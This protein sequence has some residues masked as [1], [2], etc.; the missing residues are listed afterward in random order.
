[1]IGWEH[2]G[3]YLRNWIFLKYGICAVTQQT[4][5]NF[6]YKQS[7]KKILTK[8]SA[9]FKKLGGCLTRLRRCKI[10]GK[11]K[12]NWEIIDTHSQ[13]VCKVLSWQSIYWVWASC[14]KNPQS[15]SR[16]SNPEAEC[17][18]TNN[19]DSNWYFEALVGNT[20]TWLF[21]PW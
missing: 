21:F 2:F 4:K 13:F 7:Q 11:R 3:T 17:A 5:F 12:K 1:M 10:F 15:L 16:V 20:A 19:L 6:C 14:N 18:L 9:K 8:F